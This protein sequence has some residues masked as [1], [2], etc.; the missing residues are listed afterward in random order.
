MKQKTQRRNKKRSKTSKRNKKTKSKSKSK[1]ELKKLVFDQSFYNSGDGMLTKVWGPSLWHYLH[2]MSFNYPTKPTKCDKKYYKRFMHT[3][4][5]VLPC[6]YCRENYKKNLKALPLHQD[7]FKSRL[8]FSKYM[9]RLHEHVNK[10]LG[11]TSNLTYK[12]VRDRYEHFRARCNKTKKNNRK[13][14]L[15][16]SN[17]DSNHTKKTMKNRNKSRNTKKENGCIDPLHGIK[18]RCVVHIVPQNKSCVGF[19]MDPDIKSI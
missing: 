2:T 18:S 14:K 10:M 1:S 9:Y 11:K 5:Y 12:Q 13:G 7:V 19:K 17:S 6:R 3:L 15:Q 8:S 16:L 4:K